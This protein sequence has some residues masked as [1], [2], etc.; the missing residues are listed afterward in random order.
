MADQ[1]LKTY[2]V[3]SLG[4]VPSQIVHERSRHR[5][6]RLEDSRYAKMVR[7]ST[8]PSTHVWTKRNRVVWRHLSRFPHPGLLRVYERVTDSYG[9]EGFLCEGLLVPEL[10]SG[11]HPA[12]RTL[13]GFL[14]ACEQLALAAGHMHANG[15][16]HGDIT[17]GNVCFRADGTPVLIDFDTSVKSGQYLRYPGESGEEFSVLTPACCSPEQIAGELVFPSSDVYCLAITALSW[18]SGHV[19]MQ[20]SFARTPAA[21]IEMCRHGSYPHWEL[22]R[23][24]LGAHRVIDVFA[25]ALSVQPGDR[26]QD[27]TALAEA[28]VEVRSSLTRDVLSMALLPTG[29]APLLGPSGTT[30]IL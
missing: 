11:F 23:E 19:G 8:E 12:A 16:V 7:H 25:K 20:C 18:V 17:P 28:L 13:G 30:I 26:Y 21:Q 22:A 29:P 2:V 15:Y 3:T 14:W 1:R 6:H 9:D 4:C 5:I 27:G 10:G 24:A